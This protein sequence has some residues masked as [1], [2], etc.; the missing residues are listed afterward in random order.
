MTGIFLPLSGVDHQQLPIAT[1][2]AFH[3]E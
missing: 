2:L 1:L 3:T